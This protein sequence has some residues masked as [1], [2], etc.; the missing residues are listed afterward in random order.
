MPNKSLGIT[1]AAGFVSLWSAAAIGFLTAGAVCCCANVN[2][3]LHIDDGL[4]VF[5]LHGIGGMVG[6]FLTGIFATS[7]ISALDGA[8]IASGAIDG[9]GIQVAKQL[10]EICAI[11]AY[12][13]TASV[14]MLMILKY[15]PGFHL[16]VTDEE[17]ISGYDNHQ[18]HDETIGEWA[19][20]EQN[21]HGVVEGKEPD[22]EQLDQTVEK[23]E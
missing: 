17:E 21:P 23:K 11:S 9:N 16:R 13:F 6:G 12:S 20:W 3:W 5:K 14:A 18:F 4:E 22:V 15:V 7:R 1:P 19:L 8:T 10:A 2:E